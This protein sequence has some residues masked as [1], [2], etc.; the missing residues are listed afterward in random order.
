MIKFFFFLFHYRVFTFGIGSGVSTELVKGIARA[1]NGRAEFVYEGERIQPKVQTLYIIPTYRSVPRL[2]PL[3][4]EMFRGG[5]YARRGG[6]FVG[7]YGT[8]T[9]KCS[10]FL[11]L[12]Y[13][14]VIYEACKFFIGSNFS[15]M[16]R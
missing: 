13:I 14:K 12:K 8:F 5:A 11:A 3:D 6:V 16:I 1:G 2:P 10:D 4:R 15:P 7:H 9:C